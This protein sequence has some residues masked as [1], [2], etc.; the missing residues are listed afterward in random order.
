MSLPPAAIEHAVAAVDK[1]AATCDGGG[2]ECCVEV[3]ITA[4]LAWVDGDSA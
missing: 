2:W 3:A 1:H 4:Y